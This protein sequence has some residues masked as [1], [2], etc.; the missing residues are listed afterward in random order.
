[1]NNN[2]LNEELSQMKYLFGY[3][4]GKVISEQTSTQQ[5]P[6]KQNQPAQPTPEE[7]VTQDTDNSIALKIANA[8]KQ[9]LSYLS[10]PEFKNKIILNP[11]FQQDPGGVPS[12]EFYVIGV[13]DGKTPA[14]LMEITVGGKGR[15][16]YPKDIDSLIQGLTSTPPKYNA[17]Q[18]RLPD[19]FNVVTIPFDLYE[20]LQ[21]AQAEKNPRPF[22]DLMKSI[23]PK[24]EEILKAQVEKIANYPVRGASEAR[25]LLT[26]LYPPTDSTQTPK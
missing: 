19:N 23:N 12:L 24:A 26:K 14:Q 6:V 5:Q 17:S 18:A 1:M 25:D 9:N 11:R 10:N 15:Q 4:P 13:G 21:F 20:L 8:V 3:K 16:D 7:P 22:V 2:I